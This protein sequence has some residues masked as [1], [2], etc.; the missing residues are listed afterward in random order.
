MKNRILLSVFILSALSGCASVPTANIAQ[1]NEA[2]Q[3]EQPTDGKA[4]LYVFRVDSPVGAALKKDVFLNGGCV[5]ETAPGVFFYQE[6]DAGKEYIIS[7]ES[8]FSPNALKVLT[9]SGNLY[10][11]EQYIKMGLFVG[12]ADVRLVDE[13]QGKQSITETTMAIQ[14]TCNSV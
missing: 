3:F 10:F 14:G 12:G 4:G 6:V 11:I 13:V 9:E 7:T 2:K 8:E 5:G 1:S